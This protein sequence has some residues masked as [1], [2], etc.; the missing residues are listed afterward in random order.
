ME[1]WYRNEN[2][3]HADASVHRSMDS[4]RLHCPTPGNEPRDHMPHMPDYGIDKKQFPMLIP[5]M[6]INWMDLPFHEPGS[7]PQPAFFG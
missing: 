2:D 5:V 6:T 3:P 1:G 4:G 7:P